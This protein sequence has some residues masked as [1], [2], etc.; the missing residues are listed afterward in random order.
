MLTQIVRVPCPDCGNR[1]RAARRACKRRKGMCRG[2]G[3]VLKSVP[4]KRE[5]A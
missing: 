4:I 5:A 3:Y 1:N 2:S